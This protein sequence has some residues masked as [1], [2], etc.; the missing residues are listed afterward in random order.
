MKDIANQMVLLSVPAELLEEIGLEEMDV[1]QMSTMNGK[2][3]IEKA[4]AEGY[5]C[6]GDCEGCPFVGLDCDGNYERCPCRGRCDEGEGGE[7]DEDF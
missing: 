5:I 4:D 7:D 2:L 1:L 6:D 3:I